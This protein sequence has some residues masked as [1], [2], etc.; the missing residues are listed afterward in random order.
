MTLDL[1]ISGSSVVVDVQSKAMRFLP[2]SMADM[3]NTHFFHRTLAF[4]QGR[5]L[6]EVKSRLAS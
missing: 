5:S 6:L 1:S 4:G 2:C 3:V